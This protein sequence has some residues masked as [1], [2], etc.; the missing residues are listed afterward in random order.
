MSIDQKE[1]G[2]P[3]LRN[4]FGYGIGDFGL[5]IYWQTV[6][7]FLVF[8]YT[9]IAGLGPRTAGILFFA[10]MTW[11]AIS[12]PIVA[13]ISERV[14]T[15]FGTYR[16]F[17]LFGCVVTGLS[18][19]LLFWVPPFEG[20]MKIAFLALAA[21]TF[22]TCYT[23]V[24][25]PYAALAS[26]ITYESNERAE[27]SGARMFFAFFAFVIVSMWL[28]PSVDL[29]YQMTKSR[30]QAF[31]LTSAIGGIVASLA[32]F[33]CF[34]MTRE[35]PVPPKS[36]I[37]DK[38]WKGIWVSLKSN[39]AL[40]YI[41]PV[42]FLNTAATSMLS[43]ILIFYIEASGDKFASKEIL[44]TSFA[45]ATLI[46]IP[47]WTALIKKIGRKKTWILTSLCYFFVAAHMFLGPEIIIYGV[48]VHILLFM[49]LGGAH[50]I[51]FW[52]L[53]PDCVEYGQFK[54]GYRSEAGV[55][56]ITLI[57]QKITGGLSGLIIGFMLASFGLE[58]NLDPSRTLAESLKIF[59][60]LGPTLMVMI[61][62]IPI[63][64]MDMNRSK[65]EAILLD[66]NLESNRG[67]DTK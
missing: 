16:P 13:S 30:E 38:I 67:D 50:A 9:Q 48:P 6:S 43:I 53:I 34:K 23:L 5:N 59:I 3:K 37:S 49:A 2:K 40:H 66:L 39:R 55:Y 31:Q 33:L 4:L 20:K 15:K 42:V 65:H 54:T 19:T 24:A 45:I 11:D 22:R 60:T 32:L 63:Y 28:W 8:W 47:I 58:E 41:M 17:I 21:L 29:F 10:G 56:G 12:D 36:V 46:M 18:F 52:A 57:T 64:L 1:I 35:K 7:M 26:R 44:F 62:I 51:I 14:N 25:V 27:Y 61:S